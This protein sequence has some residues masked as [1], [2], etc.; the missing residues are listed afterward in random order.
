VKNFR[1]KAASNSAI[2]KRNGKEP[3]GRE[4]G[5]IAK[6]KGQWLG[7]RISVMKGNLLSES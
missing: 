6:N 7:R 1:E 3:A 4:C 2:G 5:T